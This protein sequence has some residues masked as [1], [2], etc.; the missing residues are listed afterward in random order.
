MYPEL[1]ILGIVLPS[2]HLFFVI[3]AISAFL[4]FRSQSW[5]EIHE[6]SPIEQSKLYIAVY[7][8]TFLGARLAGLLLEE[9]IPLAQVPTELF[10]IGPMISFGG[11]LGA[12]LAG[13]F[14]CIWKKLDLAKVSDAAFPCG[15]LAAAL[16]RIGCF[17]NGDDYGTSVVLHG[18]NIP[19]WAVSFPNHHDSIPRYPI[20]LIETFFLI[21]LFFCLKK[22]R[23]GILR[24][25]GQ[26]GLFGL[27]LLCYSI[28][29]IF[30]EFFRGDVRPML[31]N[32]SISQAQIICLAGILFS[33]I[34][35]ATK[36][37][38]HEAT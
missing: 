22:L 1:S 34:Y 23:H 37:K 25:F 27:T 14:F 21:C 31:L 38:T 18:N 28:Q 35:L 30:V 6:L 16:G 11:F 17:L 8:M 19:I 20:Q 3:A 5:Q 33:L 36:N 10:K 4:S 7:L 32:T 24:H 26:G 9:K 15:M 2:W 12:F 29:R 13:A